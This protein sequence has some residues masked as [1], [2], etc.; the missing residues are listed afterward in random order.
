MAGGQG[1]VSVPGA[2]GNAGRPGGGLETGRPNA[3]GVADTDQSPSAQG[4]GRGPG[5]IPGAVKLTD[6]IITDADRLGEGGQIEKY[7]N[8]IRATGF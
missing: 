2:E 3:G 1:A 8:N 4:R 6:Y 5:V 7:N